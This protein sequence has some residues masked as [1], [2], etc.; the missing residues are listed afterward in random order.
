LACRRY[1][2]ADKIKRHISFKE[3]NASTEKKGGVEKFGIHLFKKVHPSTPW[4]EDL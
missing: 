2:H 1:N 4:K 3:K